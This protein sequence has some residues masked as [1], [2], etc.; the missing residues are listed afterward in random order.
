MSESPAETP[1]G[2]RATGRSGIEK[3]FAKGEGLSPLPLLIGSI[4]LE[5]EPQAKLHLTGKVRLRV[6]QRIGKL[7]GAGGFYAMQPGER[8][9]NQV[10]RTVS[11]LHNSGLG[12][13]L[14]IK[15]IV[16]MV[17]IRKPERYGRE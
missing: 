14:D 8:S 2:C 4:C 12:D 1:R 13:A 16:H 3:P 7:G 6:E 11:S 9:G 10:Q 17:E 15:R 5:S